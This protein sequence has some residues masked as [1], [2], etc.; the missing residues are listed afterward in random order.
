MKIS[1]TTRFKILTGL[2]ALMVLPATLHPAEF[3]PVFTDG[4]VLQR[5]RPVSI[6]GTGQEG[7]VVTVE[8][9]NQSASA[10]VK[11]RKWR[12]TLPP[13]PAT[14]S[15]TLR[16]G[17]TTSRELSNIAI[18]EVWL[19]LGQSNMEWRLN[20]CGEFSAEVLRTADNA[21]IRQLKIPLR[22]YAGDPMPAF[23]W[24]TFDAKSAGFFSAVTYFFASKLQQELGV[25]VGIINCSFGGT[26]IEAWMS[27]KAL[28]AAGFQAA[29][30]EHDRRLAVW[31]DPA[32]YD[33]AWNDYQSARK[34]WDARKAADPSIT[35]PQPVEPYGVRTKAR[36]AGLHESM[37]SLITPYTTRGVLW[38]Q[39]EN[40]AGRPEEYA[41]LLPEFV[42][43]L[44]ESWG[45][46]NLPFFVAQVS[47]PTARNPDDGDLFAKLREV[48][49]AS[50]LGDPHSGFVVTLDR[51]KQGDV[52]PPDKQPI[53]ERFAR[54]A[55]TRTYG[56]KGLAAQSPSAASAVRTE[57]G[58]EISF[59]DLP[60]RL[61]MDQ[62][63]P[64][65]F[66]LKNAAGEW[67][68]AESVSISGDGKKLIVVPPSGHVPVSV[69]Y[70]Y[71]N[72]CPLPLLTDEGLPV[73]PWLKPVN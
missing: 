1:P 26:T 18:G 63:N 61:E 47:S 32:A 19:G 37:L 49:T 22:P 33:T 55:L 29:V 7:D 30:D 53:G 56:Q 3:A 59:S 67:R 65:L 23:A 10:T 25:V 11:D 52:H 2:A 50:A 40:N 62:P 69:S 13:L 51:G 42:R 5:D 12:V 20:Q 57:G 39:G 68:P 41:R 16:L 72:F 34:A 9:L 58:V 46:S 17:G 31:S 35:D 45:Q 38:Y 24:K 36:P 43:E 28:T 21:G 44:R 70:A 27:R 60:G 4:G 14:A 6:W 8:I 48:Q 54:L 73:S 64:A 71:Q 15:T 66:R